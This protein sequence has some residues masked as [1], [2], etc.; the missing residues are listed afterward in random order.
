MMNG[1]CRTAS[2]VRAAALHLGHVLDDVRRT[3]GEAWLV[4]AA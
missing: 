3:G 2:G 4:S 1:S